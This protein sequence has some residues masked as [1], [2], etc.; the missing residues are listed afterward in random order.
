MRVLSG[1]PSR[2]VT[3]SD[4]LRNGTPWT[5]CGQCGAKVRLVFFGSD[6]KRRCA[7]CTPKRDQFVEL[8]DAS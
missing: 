8:V 5:R 1:A 3:T 4:D 2:N 7:D 6:G